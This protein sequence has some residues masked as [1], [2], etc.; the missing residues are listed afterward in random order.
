MDILRV[1]KLGE[2]ILEYGIDWVHL[3]FAD[4]TAP[5]EDWMTQFDQKRE[6][7]LDSIKQGEKLSFT[8]KVVWEGQELLLPYSYCA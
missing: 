7:I 3:P 2:T 8:A 6:Q 5:D 1:P 4:T